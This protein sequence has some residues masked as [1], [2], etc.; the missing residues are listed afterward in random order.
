M[1]LADLP[2]EELRRYLVL[3]KGFSEKGAKQAVENFRATMAYAG[4]DTTPDYVR[5]QR[6]ETAK[7]AATRAKG[8]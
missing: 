5:Q 1:R 4:L 8:G 7:R 6:W 2:N 3:A